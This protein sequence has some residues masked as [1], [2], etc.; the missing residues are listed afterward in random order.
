MKVLNNWGS[1]PLHSSTDQTPSL[2]PPD[3][4]MTLSPWSVP[5]N[6]RGYD[7]RGYS[8]GPATKM[9]N[10]WN[11]ICLVPSLQDCP[12]CWINIGPVFPCAGPTPNG[13]TVR[14]RFVST[15]QLAE[16][17]PMGLT[18]HVLNYF[19]MNLC[20]V[21]TDHITRQTLPCLANCVVLLHVS[22]IKKLRKVTPKKECDLPNTCLT[23]WINL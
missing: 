22:W 19:F 15:K 12:K 7:E 8:L 11:R 10:L 6:S 1:E 14:L 4:A 9:F 21:D 5:H 16:K 2:P 23:E 17:M 13:S 18:W 3:F 20:W